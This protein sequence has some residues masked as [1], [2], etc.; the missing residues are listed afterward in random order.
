MSK[1][2]DNARL[3]PYFRALVAS[4]LFAEAIGFTIHA[5]L[6]EMDMVLCDVYALM[7]ASVSYL[8][9]VLLFKNRTD[10]KERPKPPALASFHMFF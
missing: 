2:V 1:P 6:P 4:L 5:L 7:A 3:V 9:F 8:P 10:G